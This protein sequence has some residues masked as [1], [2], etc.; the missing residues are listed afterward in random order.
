VSSR[1]AV[2]EDKARSPRTNSGAVAVLICL[3]DLFTDLVVT[4]F[5]GRAGGY[6][7]ESNGDSTGERTGFIRIWRSAVP[8]S[9]MRTLI[10]WSSTIAWLSAARA[11]SIRGRRGVA[12]QRSVAAG[13]A[14]HPRLTRSAGAW[15]KPIQ[16]T[17]ATR[18]PYR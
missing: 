12:G 18:N 15:P 8:G 2:V 4:A 5:G 14:L 1:V 10:A 13:P 11:V 7:T 9:A 3:E 6:A 17:R 16:A